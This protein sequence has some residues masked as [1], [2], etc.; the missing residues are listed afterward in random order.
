MTA[1]NF[2][3]RGLLAG[4]I[5]GI[6]SFCVAY[7][8]GEPPVDAAI[9]LEEAGAAAEPA[10]EPAAESENHSHDEGTAEHSHDEAAAEEGGHSHDDEGG[11]TREQQSTW[12]LLTGTLAVGLALGGLVSLVAA[13]VAGRWGRLSVTASTAL[14]AG[15][16]FVA[17]ALVPFLKY[18]AAPPAVGSG[19]TIGERTTYY[20]TMLLISVLA[21]VAGTTLA[22]RLRRSL[23]AYVSV[24]AGAAVFVVV[25]A[26][27]A[28]AM[29]SVD[30]IGD[31]P[32]STLWEFR[33]ASILTLATMWAGIGVVLSGLLGKLAAD[34]TT[35]AE[36]DAARKELAMSL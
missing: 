14:V 24:L 20:F 30:E 31:F 7:T 19:D 9:A 13:G 34:E 29:P 23:S 32:A 11:I 21:A 4:L 17:V 22:V 5:A 25:V 8:I 10:A 27:A 18:P 15:I 26:V 36:Q 35:K 1:R 12:G 2:L 33:I 6:L 3:V 16:G 28:V